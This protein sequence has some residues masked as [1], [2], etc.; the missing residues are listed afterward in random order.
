MVISVGSYYLFI[1]LFLCDLTFLSK[2]LAQAQKEL[3]NY[4]NLGISV[5]GMLL[6][7]F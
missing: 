5:M 7:L 4:G 6:M 1:L 3:V 2:V